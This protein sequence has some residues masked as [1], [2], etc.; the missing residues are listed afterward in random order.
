MQTANRRGDLL[1]T[2]MASIQIPLELHT[3]LADSMRLVPV[4]L[5][6]SQLPG[7][8][9][10]QRLALHLAPTTL[11]IQILQAVELSDSMARRDGLDVR[12]LAPDL[13]VHGDILGVRVAAQGPSQGYETPLRSDEQVLVVRVAAGGAFGLGFEAA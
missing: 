2:L 6:S 1:F 4:N 8:Q 12:D 7:R 3:S 13:E 11:A 5:G 10:Y 9:T